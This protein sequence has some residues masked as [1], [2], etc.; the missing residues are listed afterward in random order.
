MG[1]TTVLAIG[2]YAALFN[3]EQAAWLSAGYVVRAAAT[4]RDA[5]KQFTDG[6]FDVVL[7]GNSISLESRERLAFLIRTSGSL[8]LVVCITDTPG[9][10]DGFADATIRNEP[11]QLLQ[12]IVELLAIKTAKSSICTANYSRRAMRT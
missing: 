9:D 5:L 10:C 3:P 11:D 1:T 4:V 6:D 2:V 12:R 8:V 7:L